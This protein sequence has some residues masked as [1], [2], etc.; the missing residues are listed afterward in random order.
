MP[1]AT[2]KS[3]ADSKGLAFVELKSVTDQLANGVVYNSTPVTS[4]PL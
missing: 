3:S 2:I 4:R 1:N